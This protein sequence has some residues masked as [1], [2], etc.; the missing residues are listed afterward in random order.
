MGGELLFGLGGVAYLRRSVGR[1]LA[2]LESWDALEA[3]LEAQQDTDRET[4]TISEIVLLR[5]LSRLTPSEAKSLSPLQRQNMWNLLPKA[6][7][8]LALAVLQVLEILGDPQAIP[9]VQRLASG[10]GVAQSDRAVRRAAQSC[11]ERLEKEGIPVTATPFSVEEHQEQQRAVSEAGLITLIDD[12]EHEHY[13]VRK[14]ALQRLP[15]LDSPAL[16]A[17]LTSIQARL[18]NLKRQWR[19][20]L[21]V[22]SAVSLGNLLM[23]EL[24]LLDTPM[25]HYANNHIQI[26]GM[27]LVIGAVLGWPL[28]QIRHRIRRD[29]SVL[30]QIDD[31]R[32]CGPLLELWHSGD[33]EMRLVA[34]AS[35]VRLLPSLRASDAAQ[36]N[37]R[38][39]ERLDQALSSGSVGLVLAVLKALEQIGGKKE[40]PRVERL[41]AGGGLAKHENRIRE[42]A[43]ECLLY[44]QQRTQGKEAN[45]TL[46]RASDRF[47]GTETLLRA[48]QGSTETPPEQLLRAGRSDP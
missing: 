31:G 45:E 36:L 25:M 27:S 33:S 48:A 16:G 5:F 41:A 26:V 46:L 7:R 11:L 19:S 35:L 13:T 21:A 17:A 38:Q 3:L 15:N 30:T 28:I 14:R 18:K 39:R 44:L 2:S 42:A 10:E 47:E 24:S 20:R 1:S 6:S 8:V 23:S 40:L 43:Q 4:R 22:A 12:L 34:E 37:A 9:E 32:V 29:Q